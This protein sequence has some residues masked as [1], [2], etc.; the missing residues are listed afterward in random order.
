MTM[1]RC[2]DVKRKGAIKNIELE[3]RDGIQRTTTPLIDVH[4]KYQASAECITYLQGHVLQMTPLK[5]IRQHCLKCMG[6]ASNYKKVKLCPNDGCLLWVYRLGKNPKMDRTGKLW[7]N[8]MGI[9]V[10]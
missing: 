8:V 5:A 10:K 4:R 2:K 3:E 7:G 9:T 6:G 1:V